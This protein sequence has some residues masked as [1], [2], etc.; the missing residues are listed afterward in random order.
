MN[1]LN[2]NGRDHSVHLP[3]S[4]LPASLVVALADEYD[5]GGIRILVA[6]WTPWRRRWKA[7]PSLFLALAIITIP[8]FAP[9]VV[10]SAII[11][12]RFTPRRRRIPSL[13]RWR[14]WVSTGALPDGVVRG[15]VAVV[16][17]RLI[18]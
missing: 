16:P 13:V 4:R 6:V 9:S 15:P 5:V 1:Q 17:A 2:G 8:V 11:L 10:A 12:P 7:L 3:E 14:T 18:E